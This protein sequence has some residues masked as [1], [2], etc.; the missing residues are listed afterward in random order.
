MLLTT[1]CSWRR[2]AALALVAAGLAACSTPQPPFPDT[3]PIFSGPQQQPFVC[4]S[5]ESGLGQ[6]QADNQQGIGHPVFDDAGKPAGHS[7]YCVIVPKVSY[8]YYNG[9]VF[10]PYVAATPPA[11]LARTTVAGVALPFVVRVEVRS[12][13]RFLTTV[14]TLAPTA[15]PQFEQAAWNGKVVYW[16]R[17]GVGVGHHQGTAMWFNEGLGSAERQLLPRILGQGYAVLSSSGNETGVHYNMQLAE[18]TALMSKAYF[19][20]AYGKPRF[21][22]GIGGSG[23]AVQ[24]YLFAQNRPGLLDAGIPIQSYPDMITQTIPVSDCPLLGRYFQDAVARDPASP[25]AAWSRQRLIEGMNA[26]DTVQNP[27]T[28]KPGSTECISGW[29]NA[30]PNVLNPVYK[31]SRFDTAAALYRYPPDVYKDVKWTHWN[32]LANIYGADSGGFAPISIDNVG[33]QYGLAALARGEIGADEFLRINACAGGWKEQPDFVDW[34]AKADPFDAR[35]MLR[36]ASCGEAAGAPAPRRAGDLAAI[37]KA[38]SAG[39][40]FTGARLEVPMIDLRPYLETELNMHNARQSFAVRARLRDANPGAVRNQVIWFAGSVASGTVNVIDALAVLERYL[41]SG[42]A[43]PEF[44]DRCVDAAG[45]QVGAGPSAWDGILDSKPAGACTRAFPIYSSPRMVAGESIKGDTFKCAL[46]PV[47][48]ALG[49]G[50]YG[51][52]APFTAAQTAWLKRIFPDGV[53]DYKRPGLGRG[54]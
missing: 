1:Q 43:P 21:T 11:D 4:R 17:G 51:S 14:A 25:W 27:L 30:L 32:D 36:S 28:G 47:D 31:D 37:R 50:S 2:A 42:S 23:G 5:Q 24:Q 6:P 38:Y 22:I 34:D 16:L 46:K 9:A 35:N 18:E 19:T 41:D 53:C 26:S 45:K 40:V 52:T 39:Q 3:G 44:V 7:R 29:R 13:N 54:D 12:I 48:A 33:V 20:R 8:F 49:D 10:K 15:A